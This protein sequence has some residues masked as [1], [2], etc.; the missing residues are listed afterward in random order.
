MTKNLNDITVLKAW[1]RHVTGYWEKKLP[2]IPGANSKQFWNILNGC[3]ASL[4][5]Q[6]RN[7]PPKP[8]KPLKAQYTRIMETNTIMTKNLNDITVLKAWY[9][10]VTGYWE[11]KLPHIPGANS[12]QF[13]NIL[14]VAELAWGASWGTVHSSPQS[15]SKHSILESWENTFRSISRKLG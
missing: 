14:M 10:H 8:P 9:R 3:W 12:K 4:R 11:K 2:H 7:C 6:L 15:P 1:Y 5:S 13:W